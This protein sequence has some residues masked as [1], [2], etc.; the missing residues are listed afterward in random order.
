[1]D[2]S[3]AAF[4][5]NEPI[6]YA[7]FASVVARLGLKP[8][9]FNGGTVS[10]KVFRD[11]A[12]WDT[13][14]P[15]AQAALICGEAGVWGNPSE[16]NYTMLGYSGFCLQDQVQRQYIASF[17][18]SMLPMQE[19]ERVSEQQFADEIRFQSAL[20]KD[21]MKRLTGE[22]IIS[23]Y[24]DGTIRPE[25][26]VTKAELAA[27]L[28]KVME[29]SQFDRN[30]ISDNLYGKY[31]SYYWDEEE[32][33]LDLV[34]DA[35]RKAGVS[36]L[37]Y[38]ADLNALCEVKMLEKSIYGLDTFTKQIQYDGKT[39]ADGHVSRFYGRC[40][41]MAR[42]FGLT[43]YYVGENAVL[44]APYA[45]KAHNR[46]T[47]SEAHRKNYLNPMYEVAGFAVGEKATY[48]MFAYVK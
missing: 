7:D 16:A 29:K 35:R 15:N 45:A 6:T 30:L 3:A 47:D 23:C 32:K 4:H 22:N 5:P 18:V 26:T 33:L 19:K 27:M 36:E 40:T 24:A 2:G 21:A 9:E 31:H 11:A 17:L 28:Y 46:L 25:G 20:C 8:V 13:A 41:A 38:D 1:M 10:H 39:I 42:A 43:D 12:L 14:Y 37:K 48:Q 44:Y 34:N